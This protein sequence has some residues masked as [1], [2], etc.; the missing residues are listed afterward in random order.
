MSQKLTDG[1][2]PTADG[3]K[4][5]VG[6]PDVSPIPPTAWGRID[7]YIDRATKIGRALLA[8]AAG[9]AV[10]IFGGCLVYSACNPHKPVLMEAFAVPEMLQTQGYTPAL[11]SDMLQDNIRQMQQDSLSD[12][13]QD[14]IRQ[15]QRDSKSGLD[16][17][18]LLRDVGNQ[19]PE[20]EVTGMKISLSALVQYL[21]DHTSTHIDGALVQSRQRLHLM[22][23]YRPGPKDTV[24]AY[25]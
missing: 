25:S 1:L 12:V 15:M 3:L 19:V 23:H 22:L 8:F 6:S 2:K 16:C 17:P 13:L 5:A 10:L 11:L 20:I 9:A 7:T 24:P 21:T 14:N 18:D 4:P